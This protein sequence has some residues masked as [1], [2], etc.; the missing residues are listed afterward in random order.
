VHDSFSVTFVHRS[1]VIFSCTVQQFEGV[2]ERGCNKGSKTSKPYRKKVKKYHLEI[3]Q[4]TETIVGKI[5]GI[6]S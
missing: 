6:K 5:R 3:Y 1:S 4:Y 2:W